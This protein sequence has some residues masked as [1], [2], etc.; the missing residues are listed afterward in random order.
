MTKNGDMR[1][2]ADFLM[3]FSRR[4]IMRARQG[5]ARALPVLISAQIMIISASPAWSQRRLSDPEASPQFPQ[6]D[7]PTSAEGTPLEAAG[8]NAPA[9]SEQPP[10]SIQI[11]PQSAVTQPS[12]FKSVSPL[13]KRV[14]VRLKEAPLAVF[15]QTISAQSKINFIITEGLESRKVTVFLQNVTVR[16]ALQVLLEIKGLTYQQ[17]G[18]SNTYIVM[19]RSKKLPNLITRIYNLSY[20]PLIPIET[21]QAEQSSITPTASMGGSSGGQSGGS[22]APSSSGS[23]AAGASASSASNGCS[24]GGKGGGGKGMGGSQIPI[25]GVVC[26]VLSSS[27][28]VMVDPR[29]NSLVV[30]DVPE[31][32]PQVEQIISALDRRTPQVMIE[33]QI[34]EIDSDREND[35]GISWGGSGGELAS[36]TGGA[37]DTSFPMVLSSNLAKTA[38]LDP[39]ANVISSLGMQGATSGAGATGG[40]GFGG[41][42][43]TSG[44]PFLNE[45]LLGSNVMTSV[46]DLSSLQ[47]V[48]RALVSHSEARFLGKPK[49]LTLNNKPAI[50]QTAQDQATFLPA[51]TSLGSGVLGSATQTETQPERFETGLT[52][53]VTPQINKAGYITMLIQPIFTNLQSSALSTAKQPIF[54]P[55][56]RSA[57]TMV[58][59]KNG[60]TLVLGGLLQS[61][62]NKVVQKV[63]FLG[64]IPI[65]GWFFTSTSSSR[66]NSDLVIFITPTIIRG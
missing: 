29:T 37:R 65:I 10:S 23:G 3:E 16:E 43:G 57:S 17:V 7:Q 32:F 50:I 46:L 58:R 5:A 64:Y 12:S 30:T 18:Q 25:V 52:L 24:G 38:F 42:G 21:L 33:A 54:D 49:I 56:T 51:I 55:I 22:A 59:V 62:E 36:F 28:Q 31:V 20:I 1:S 44:S 19:P 26:S 41:L 53:R 34:V 8:Q 35:L 47:V 4:S 13:D 66:I 39:V 2:S 63:P 14:T 61:T 6:Q 40:G 11:G 45:P 9:Y 48:L 15:L 27:G 60:Q